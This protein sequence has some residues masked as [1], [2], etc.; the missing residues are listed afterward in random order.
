VKDVQYMTTSDRL[1][2]GWMDRSID[3]SLVVIYCTSFTSSQ[4]K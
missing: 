1:M 2:D 4:T 3:R